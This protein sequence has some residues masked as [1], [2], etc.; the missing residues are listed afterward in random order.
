MERT[1]IKDSR[2][3]IVLDGPALGLRIKNGN[4]TTAH[5][6]AGRYE[7]VPVEHP[8]S[9][10]RNTLKVFDEEDNPAYIVV[11]TLPG[12]GVNLTIEA[13]GDDKDDIGMAP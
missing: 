4:K 9:P 1:I 3:W 6:K 13:D 7:A 5:I 10:G 12:Q 2:L 8:I 11:E